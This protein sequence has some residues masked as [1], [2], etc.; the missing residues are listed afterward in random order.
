MI[1]HTPLDS[2]G[3]TV[4]AGLRQCTF[5]AAFAHPGDDYCASCGNALPQVQ[6]AETRATCTRCGAFVRN[7]IAFHCTHCGAPLAGRRISP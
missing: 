7:R 2:A 5:C 3:G 4:P 1:K 6:P